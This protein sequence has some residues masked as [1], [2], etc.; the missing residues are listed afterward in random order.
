M[1]S[2]PDQLIISRKLKFQDYLP[3]DFVDGIVDNRIKL[4]DCFFKTSI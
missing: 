2:A 1:A 3:T 4:S